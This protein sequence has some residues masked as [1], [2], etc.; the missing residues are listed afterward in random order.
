M[1]NL[2]VKSVS[3]QVNENGAELEL[4]NTENKSQIQY[5]VKKEI[6]VYGVK[7][8]IDEETF[9]TKIGGTL[10]AMYIFRY[11]Y[12]NSSGWTLNS[13]DVDISE[14][15]ITLEGQPQKNDSIVISCANDEISS[16][17]Y[18]QNIEI[19]V[20]IENELFNYVG[21]NC[22]NPNIAFI[23]S[24]LQENGI[25]VSVLNQANK[26]AEIYLYSGLKT[27]IATVL[28]FDYYESATIE[29]LVAKVV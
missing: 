18:S 11:Q 12:N 27:A 28:T 22:A 16:V 1:K 4:T 14:Y 25:R 19:Y 6:V 9:K 20:G 5:L 13:T 7:P 26:R 2:V 3:K 21:V 8:T 23:V 24:G 29:I 15:G 17:K 10:S